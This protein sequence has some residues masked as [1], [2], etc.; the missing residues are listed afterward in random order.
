MRVTNFL[1]IPSRMN[2]LWVWVVALDAWDYCDPKPLS[3]L[4]KS[5]PIPHEFLQAVTEII[6]G[7][8]KPNKKAAV[9]LKIPASER[10]KIAGSISL[11]LG[12][13]N[14][15]KYDAKDTYSGIEQIAERECKEPIEVLRELELNSRQEIIDSSNELNVSV[16]TIEN[17]LRDLR[18]KINNW[19]V[20]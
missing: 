8:R 4:I 18:E 13:T 12:I 17:L 14:C 19:P 1:D 10:M 7:K 20:V 2:D 3:D 5:D 6:E 11:I 9:K 16:E 15:I